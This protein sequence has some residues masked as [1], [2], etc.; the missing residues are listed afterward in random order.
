MSQPSP[1]E[2]LL[3][4]DQGPVKPSASDELSKLHLGDLISLLQ[5]VEDDIQASQA[6]ANRSCHPNKKATYCN[7]LPAGSGLRPQVRK[8]DW[9]RFKNHVADQT[10]C[11]IDVLIA[12]SDL[13][14]QVLDDREQQA[15]G[16]EPTDL[17]DGVDQRPSNAK[18]IHGEEPWIHR[19]RIRSSAVLQLLNAVGEETLDITKAHTFMRPFVYFIFYHERIAEH[20]RMLESEAATS[21]A[22]QSLAEKSGVCDHRVIPEAVLG[23][24]R[25]YV[26]FV[27]QCLLPLYR[28]FED[29]RD[30]TAM[31]QFDD[32]WYLFRPGEL[33][34]RN[35]RSDAYASRGK[36]SLRAMAKHRV[37]RVVASTPP[38]LHIEGQGF[39]RSE[40]RRDPPPTLTTDAVGDRGKED[41]VF[42]VECY[43]LDFDGEHFVPWLFTLGIEPYS[44][45]RRIQDLCLHPLRFAECPEEVLE[46]HKAQGRKYLQ[47]IELRHLSLEGCG[48]LYEPDGDRALTRKGE[49]WPV[50]VGYVGEVYVDVKEALRINPYWALWKHGCAP[51]QTSL[52]VVIDSYPI[53]QRTYDERRDTPALATAESREMIVLD[54]HWLGREFNH[55]IRTDQ[56]LVQATGI[57]LDHFAIDE[58]DLALVPQRLYVF[59]LSSY[60]FFIPADINN[61]QPIPPEPH[62]LDDICI[63]RGM[64]STLCAVVQAHSEQSSMRRHQEVTCVSQHTARGNDHGLVVL[65]QGPPGTG[66]TATAEA[67]AQT[68]HKPLIVLCMQDMIDIADGETELLRLAEAWNAVL[69]IDEVDAFLS[70]RNKHDV[71][72]NSDVSFLLRIIET[73]SGLLFLTTCRPAILDEG[74]KSRVHLNLCL[75]PL[76]LQQT[77]KIFE[78]NLAH[79]KQTEQQLQASAP[80]GSYPLLRTFDKQILEFAEH[81]FNKTTQGTGRWNGRQIRNA[82]SIAAALA[83]YDVLDTVEWDHPQ[84]RAEHFKT[85]AALTE[86][87]DQARIRVLR[88]SDS[89]MAWQNEERC[90]EEEP[91]EQ[92]APISPA[93]RRRQ[94]KHEQRQ[95]QRQ[96]QAQVVIQTQPRDGSGATVYEEEEELEEMND[97]QQQLQQQQK[98]QQQQR[99]PKDRESWPDETEASDEDE[100]S[101]MSPESR[102]IRRD[103]RAEDQW[104]LGGRQGD[105]SSINGSLTDNRGLQYGFKGGS[106]GPSLRRYFR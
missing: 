94:Q 25:C 37:A 62:A 15:D 2:N 89:R 68:Y 10:P 102:L 32:L 14:L 8:C 26:A 51:R 66:K 36:E 48:L 27:E 75:K 42:L 56:R 52:E 95:R 91:V 35:P 84:L 9:K 24:I 74:V 78:T 40:Y 43:F 85:V 81:H 59:L 71:H 11:V 31:I 90:D 20:F 104:S 63:D 44:G 83:R 41:G 97:R 86:E 61:L 21:A 106:N 33:V 12:G 22:E 19:I 73:F 4:H 60:R 96:Q 18:M 55:Q 6:D 47:C 23:E 54:D 98:P 30:K 70:H 65:L 93:L 16:Y 58:D 105:Q 99:Q 45:S 80:P 67:I 39:F 5:K 50:T 53:R 7:Q 57:P 28:Q 13:P 103:S 100:A 64:K 29:V 38:R 87:Y 88:K 69:L 17:A 72:S 46:L 3:S 82:F 1:D 49:P 34:Y 77:I 101:L 76:N 92:A 79:L